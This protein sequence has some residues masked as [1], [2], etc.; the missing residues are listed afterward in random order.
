MINPG[1]F[2]RTALRTSITPNDN[3]L[4]LNQ[5]TGALFNLPAGD[6]CYV[7]LEDRL[8][9][10]VVKYVSTGQVVGDNLTV[11]RAQDGTVARAFPA[12]TCVKVAWNEAQVRELIAQT[13]TQ[14][15]G[16][17]CAPSIVTTS[18]G[19]P[20]APPAGCIR[21]VV[22][23]AVSPAQLYFWTG[24]AWIATSGSSSSTPPPPPPATGITAIASTGPTVITAITQNGGVSPGIVITGAPGTQFSL[25]NVIQSNLPGIGVGCGTAI[26]TLPASVSGPYTI[27][28]SGSLTLGGGD[29]LVPGYLNATW[30]VVGTSLSL[31]ITINNPC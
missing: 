6:Y 2:I 10:E 15:L 20:T 9:V 12:G 28:P 5:G 30:T 17:V 29:P 19:V 18:S 24:T 25:S 22:N 31:N 11:Q 21:F 23:T 3:V 13:V 7:T 8:N 4:P 27:P 14:M 1:N 26:I 16:T